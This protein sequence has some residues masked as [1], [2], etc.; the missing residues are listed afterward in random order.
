[1]KS[2]LLYPVKLEDTYIRV[3]DETLLPNKV[4]YI[5]VTS[6]QDACYC[7]K[8]MKT[9]SLGQVLLCCYSFVLF[10]H[11]YSIDEICCQ[12]K[13]IRPTFDFPMIGIIIRKIISGGAPL[14]HAVLSFIE[15]FDNARR[16]RAIKM[17]SL[18]PEN[19]NILTLCNVNGD[20]ILIY[21]EMIN[22]GKTA[23]FYVSET[24]PY[25]QG[26]RLTFW[27]LKES[28]IPAILICDNQA[29]QLMKEKKINSVIVGA[30]RATASGDIINKTGTYAIACMAKYFDIPFFALTQY[31]RDINVD[32]IEIE[33]RPVEE[34]FIYH[35]NICDIDAFYPAFDI[36]KGEY[37]TS[38]VE[39]VVQQQRGR[40]K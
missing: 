3:L 32:D 19:A 29:A 24:R 18:L 6:L 36:T 22:M 20:L 35:K 37:I 38:S 33:E 40:A 11:K 21:N 15:S 2:P 17:A 34:L 10:E 27:E 26:T 5:K 31:P 13:E 8:E 16:T 23:R 14:K 28:K 7:I 39:L 25:L 12:F 9:R 30:D 4:H 1:M